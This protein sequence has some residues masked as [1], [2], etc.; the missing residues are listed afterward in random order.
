MRN[1]S[2]VIS[3]LGVGALSQL[4]SANVQWS[5]CTDV[6]VG[7]VPA[8][9]GILKVPLDYTERN[10]GKTLDL[11]LVR[12][13]ARRQ[14]CIGSVLYNPGGPGVQAR[15]ALV[16][17]ADGMFALTASLGQRV[18]IMISL[19]LILGTSQI[20]SISF[21]FVCW[22]T[23]LVSSG[24]RNALPFTCF[25]NTEEQSAAM[26]QT[27]QI[28]WDALTSPAIWTEASDT[29]LGKTWAIGQAA[30]EKC[31]Q[32][33]GEV[34]SLIG[35]AFAVR[36]MM[37]IVNALEPDGMLRYW[38]RW[39]PHGHFERKNANA[40]SCIG[41]SYG[42]ILG[43]TAAAMFPDRI[44]RMVLDGVA[45]P[46]DYY[47]GSVHDRQESQI[48][49]SDKV[50][51]HFFEACLQSPKYCALSASNATAE[52]L[53]KQTWDLLEDIKYHPRT[54]NGTIIDHVRLK[55]G[56][57][58]ALY[59]PSA[60]PSMAAGLYHLANGNLTGFAEAWKSLDPKI[61]VQMATAGIRCSDRRPR[62]HDFEQFQRDIQDQTKVSR[63][64]GSAH[65]LLDAACPL[66]KVEA[67]ERYNGSFEVRTKFPL[68]IIGNTGDFITPL[69]SARNVSEG[70]EGS[71]L[72]HHDGYGH[73]SLAQVSQC[74]RDA[75][76][77]YYTNGTLPEKGTVCKPDY[78]PF[79]QPQ[80]GEE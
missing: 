36:D 69:S 47:G 38:G 30:A 15:K 80:S 3:L 33:H 54:F 71:V 27:P 75:T 64:M 66:W 22:E 65:S 19:L 68:L 44:D 16:D 59:S 73:G 37:E 13:P 21:L 35:T 55:N 17:D 52:V 70:F 62:H 63:F 10:S 76:A 39:T 42:T 29:G 78:P 6:N 11:D 26:L 1:N 72:L 74:T 48:V 23:D 77:A 45:I 53:E 7:D 51:S 4:G 46:E 41:A 34:G 79:E 56:M 2:K 12:I 5:N 24:T 25:N 31:Y 32:G 20:L 60:W 67:K 14:P 8:E 50:F 58:A 61:G 40:H 28:W 18:D 57:L 9:C 43:A 49:D